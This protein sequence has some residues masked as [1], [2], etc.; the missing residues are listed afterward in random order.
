MKVTVLPYWLATLRITYLYNIMLSADFTSVSKRYQSHT[1]RRSRLR[2][3]DTRCGGRSGSWFPPFRRASPDN[4]RWEE[5]E[6]SLLCSAADNPDCFPRARNS[7][8][9]LPRR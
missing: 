4:D 7:N 9:L 2:G 8:G 6:N 5:Q 3:G 1:V